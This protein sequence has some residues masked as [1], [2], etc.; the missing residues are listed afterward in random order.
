MVIMI[1]VI[2]GVLFILVGLVALALQRFYSSVPAKE[3]K[4]LASRGDHLAAALYRP[5]AYGVSMR[6]L[7]W[8]IFCLGLTGGFLLVLYN[9]ASVVAFLI[10]GAS[11]A[12]V[13]LLQSVRLTVRSAHFAVKVAPALNWLMV[14]LHAPFDL[15]ARLLNRYRSRAAHSG[16]Y[17]K[18]D[19]LELLEQQKDQPDNRIAKH[20]LELLARAAKFDDRQAADITLPMSRVK[21][22]SLTDHIG[23]I[24]LGELHDSGQNSFLVYEETPDR[25]VGTLFLRDAVASKEGGQVRSLMHPRLCFVHEDFSLRQVLQAF[26]RTGQFMVVVVN[27][28]EEPVGVITLSHLL[29]Q[30]LGEPQEDDFDAFENRS[31]VAAFKPKLTEPAVESETEPAILAEESSDGRESNS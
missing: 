21:L 7:L 9:T 27:V 4:R 25:V 17:E 14:Y 18:E 1:I 26:A 23:P 8:V 6:L 5:V 13:V 19:L 16:L 3:L 20:D 31:A 10:V 30:L 28:F 2:L 22:V 11:V 12:G 15:A 29:T 24:L